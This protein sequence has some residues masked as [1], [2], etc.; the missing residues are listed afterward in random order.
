[1][2]VLDNFYHINSKVPPSNNFIISNS[3][4]KELKRCLKTELERQFEDKLNLKKVIFQ[5][6][7]NKKTNIHN[8]KKEDYFL[9]ESTHKHNESF[10]NGFILYYNSHSYT[11]K[12]FIE[13]LNAD[14]PI[15]DPT[16]DVKPNSL[17]M[18]LEFSDSDIES[19]KDFAVKE[20]T[21]KRGERVDGMRFEIR[22]KNLNVDC[23]F[24][25]FLEN[26][27][28]KNN[29]FTHFFQNIIEEYNT[30]SENHS[31]VLFAQKSDT[32]IYA[33]KT[34]D[35]EA[36]TNYFKLVYMYD[37]FKETDKIEDIKKDID[38]SVELARLEIE[39]HNI[40]AEQKP[41]DTYVQP[42]GLIHNFSIKNT[43]DSTI[44]IKVDLGSSSHGFEYILKKL[45][46]SDFPIS[47]VEIKGF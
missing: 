47:K 41:E 33:K 38:N 8:T 7:T 35:R 14:W 37:V 28:L 30:I 44:T 45:D 18:R 26:E 43:Q 12:L 20:E 34:F 23:E 17:K 42:T 11:P 19:L 3:I 10:T 24:R 31:H 27:N 25:I 39:K 29:I 6:E 21:L 1:M 4:K 22:V 16:N 5:F 32:K 46:E 40:K 36:I 15:I 13:N 9:K 2:V